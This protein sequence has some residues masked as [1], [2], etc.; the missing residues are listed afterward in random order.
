MFYKKT[1]LPEDS[2]IVMCTVTKIQ[3]SSVFVE[4]DEYRLPGMIHISEIAAGRIRN[5]RDYVKEGKKIVCKVLRV[6]QDRGQVDLSLRRVAEVQKRKKINEMK[7]EQ[8]AETIIKYIAEQ[9]KLPLDKTYNDIANI[10]LKKYEYIHF[11][12]Q[13][14]AEDKTL[15][16]VAELQMILDK[17]IVETLVDL[18]EQRFKAKLVEVSGVYEISTYDSN[19]IEI[20]K[21][22]L[23]AAKKQDGAQIFYLG[24]GRYKIVVTATDYKDAEAKLKQAN[25]DAALI[26]EKHHGNFSFE[27]K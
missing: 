22:A 16:V 20:V 7:V 6:Y 8:K 17:K 12:F 13:A 26:V 19:G 1:G 3:Y 9:N 15:P 11:A 14:I 21:N 5:I 23:R 4:L 2:E 24:G 25:E 10:I 18:V 27:R